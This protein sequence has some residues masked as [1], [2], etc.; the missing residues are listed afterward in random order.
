MTDIGRI[1]RIKK[2]NGADYEKNNRIF[3][4]DVFHYTF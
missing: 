3:T 1:A 4:A 2:L